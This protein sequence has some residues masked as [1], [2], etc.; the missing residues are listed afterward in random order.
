MYCCYTDRVAKLVVGNKASVPSYPQPQTLW[1]TRYTNV[2]LIADATLVEDR[3]RSC[4][5]AQ[6]VSGFNVTDLPSSLFLD[7]NSL[8]TVYLLS[9]VSKC[10]IVFLYG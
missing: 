8:C 9:V 1:S 7:D 6:L 3:V 10:E 5:Y 4:V 2:I